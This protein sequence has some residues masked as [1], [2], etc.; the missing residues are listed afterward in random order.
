MKEEVS[1]CEPGDLAGIFST[2]ET[3]QAPASFFRG[4][5]S[6]TLTPLMKVGWF[7]KL[8][9]SPEYASKIP[10]QNR[11][12]SCSELIGGGMIAAESWTRTTMVHFES[13]SLSY[14]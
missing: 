11:T 1:W 12:A 2:N 9:G 6:P 13:Y 10:F 5:F 7:R 4:F 3:T 14:M 8:T